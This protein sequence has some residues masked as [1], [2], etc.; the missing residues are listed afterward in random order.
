MPASSSTGPVLLLRAL[1]ALAVLLPLLGLRT[2][3]PIGEPT[4]PSVRR[5]ATMRCY[6]TFAVPEVLYLA[7]QHLVGT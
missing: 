7:L 4:P 6:P 3:A 1:P 5:S 2:L